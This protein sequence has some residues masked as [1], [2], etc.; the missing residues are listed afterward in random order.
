M[1]ESFDTAKKGV[2]AVGGLMGRGVPLFELDRKWE[3]LRKRPDIDIAFFKAFQ[4]ERGKGEFRKFVVDPDN[5]TPGEREKLASISH[6]FLN[7]IPKEENLVI[8]G[9]GI[10]QNAFYEVIQDDN[11]RAVLGDSPYRLT[12]DFAMIQCAWAM[13]QLEQN[14]KQDKEKA[15]NTSPSRVHVSFFCDESEEHSSRAIEAYQNLKSNNQN[16]AEYMA[17]FSTGNDKAFNVLQAADACVF[18]I[19]R[20][21]NLALGQWR[22]QL[23]EQ[24]NILADTGKLFLISHATKD[25][26]LHI[27]ATHEPGAPFRLDEIME[28]QINEN[29][30]L[31]I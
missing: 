11:A 9:V 31:A 10:D 14:I 16:A 5:V 12:Y 27:A 19:R 4:C 2:F 21:L 23:R 25:Q 29:V 13:K 7:L 24:F 17:T 22:G 30:K 20:A 26:L 8:Q 1:D 28:W 15:M 18:E 6:E 3:R